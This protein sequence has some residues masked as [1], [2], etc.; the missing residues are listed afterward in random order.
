MNS[1]VKDSHARSSL[2][3]EGFI[4]A[5]FPP[6]SRGPGVSAK[7]ERTS[8]PQL[9]FTRPWSHVE[10]SVLGR[11]VLMCSAAH[12]PKLCAPES[13]GSMSL[14]ACPACPRAGSWKVHEPGLSPIRWGGFRADP[15]MLQSSEGSLGLPGWS[16]GVHTLS[17][18]QFFH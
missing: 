5:S 16:Q 3:C 4:S 17:E 10:V 15:L 11:N 1:S 7:W 18:P 8:L 12:L 9:V 6:Q 2:C 14:F 13:S